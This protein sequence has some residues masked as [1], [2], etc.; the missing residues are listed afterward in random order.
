MSS[1]KRN[2]LSEIFKLA[3]Q[4]VKRNGYKLSEAL[5]CAWLNIKLK[6]EM[7]KRIAINN[8]RRQ[9]WTDYRETERYPF[10]YDGADFDQ[11][12]DCDFGIHE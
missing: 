2:K 10:S 4:F 1:E 11:W 5:K 9:C 8:V 12:G 6:A 7:K 3:W